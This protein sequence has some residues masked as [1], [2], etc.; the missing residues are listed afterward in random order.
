H[1]CRRNGPARYSSARG[2]SGRSQRRRDHRLR[3]AP[4]AL[5]EDSDC[6]IDR[7]LQELKAVARNPLGVPIALPLIVELLPVI[8]TGFVG[9]ELAVGFRQTAEERLVRQRD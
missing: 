1:N 8:R 3:S 6:L 7:T 9:L 2:K 4:L 5:F